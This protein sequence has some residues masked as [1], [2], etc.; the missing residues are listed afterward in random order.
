MKSVSMIR[1]TAFCFA[2]GLAT[3]SMPASA[4]DRSATLPQTMDRAAAQGDLD[5]ARPK[6]TA[7]ATVME[8]GRDYLS[9]TS[10]IGS[11]SNAVGDA[12]NAESRS[13]ECRTLAIPA[14][15]LDTQSKYSSNDIS[16]STVDEE[17]AGERDKV[18][19]PIRNAVRALANMAHN[20]KGHGDVRLARAECVLRN[21]DAWA[22]DGSLTQMKSADALLT[23]DRLVAEIVLAL[24][25]ASRIKPVDASRQQAYRAWL[26]AIAEDTIEA[27]TL[28]LGP[29]ARMN[30][31]R[32]W[33]GLSVA[34][35]GFY[36]GDN[37]FKDW[38]KGSFEIGACQVDERGFLPAELA[39]GQKAL[40]YH[41]Y[42]L[43][44]LA[45]ISKIAHEEGE[46]I[47]SAC[48]DGFERL[49]AQTVQSL[50]DIKTFEV[51]VGRAQS[52]K[53]RESSYSQAL[54]LVTLQLTNAAGSVVY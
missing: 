2:A 9:V 39:R 52:F 3:A 25:Q 6:F 14:R 50:S 46:P 11:R 19:L 20:E 16:K 51:L 47:Q 24:R 31:H 10:S 45:A 13:F 44:P 4:A 26:T 1:Y 53:V 38:G 28:R 54:R 37:R 17:A 30:N 32:Y 35:T 22:R 12:L 8:P 36:L 27:Y 33:A 41:L 42:A 49:S 18:I 21:L 23:R 48:I 34:A 29:K 7:G 43:R 40:E 15:S 5:L